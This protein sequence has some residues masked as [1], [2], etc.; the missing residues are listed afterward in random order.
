MSFSIGVATFPEDGSVGEELMASFER[1][2][3]KVK[4]EINRVFKT[5]DIRRMGDLVF[6]LTMTITMMTTYFK[7]CFV[8]L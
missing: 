7:S 6:C 3:E 5:N 1:M 2:S 8:A 4:D